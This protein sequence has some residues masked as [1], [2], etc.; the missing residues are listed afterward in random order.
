MYT[1]I[2][3]FDTHS[4]RRVEW[5]AIAL[6]CVAS[7]QNSFSFVWT[8]ARI[9]VRHVVGVRVPIHWIFTKPANARTIRIRVK[10]YRTKQLIFT[11]RVHCILYTFVTIEKRKKN[12]QVWEIENKETEYFACYNYVFSVSI[13]EAHLT[14]LTEKKCVHLC[15][16][17]CTCREELDV[18]FT[19]IL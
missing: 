7:K 9:R 19:R 6:C 1:H 15:V 18:L 8:L 16:C 4:K 14:V 2:D 3:T 11:C 5:M 12:S 13:I 17:V 10:Q